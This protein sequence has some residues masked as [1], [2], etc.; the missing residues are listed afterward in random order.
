MGITAE[1]LTGKTPAVPAADTP[2]AAQVNPPVVTYTPKTDPAEF[3]PCNPNPDPEPDQQA[4]EPESD[5]P[6]AP[7]SPPAL[8]VSHVE[9]EL[10]YIPLEA[11]ISE[12]TRRMPKAE[13][14]LRCV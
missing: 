3:Q 12:I 13:V 14:V 9:P 7:Q 5:A 10:A 8:L 2:P 4:D 6:Q 1:Q 11:L